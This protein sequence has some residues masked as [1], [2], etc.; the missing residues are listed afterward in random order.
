MV[1]FGLR[2][3]SYRQEEF[4]NANRTLLSNPTG[5]L[6]KWMKLG[7]EGFDQTLLTECGM[8]FSGAFIK[9]H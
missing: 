2:C 6:A 4:R 9:T 8:A 5:C 7:L 3:L 1:S